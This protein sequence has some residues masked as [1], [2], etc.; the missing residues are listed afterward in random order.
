MCWDLHSGAGRKIVKRDN[1][2]SH[3]TLATRMFGINWQEDLI[4]NV[5]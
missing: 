4:L 3:Y 5:S 1:F 2:L